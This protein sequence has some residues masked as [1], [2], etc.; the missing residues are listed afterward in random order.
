MKKAI[1]ILLPLV[2]VAS[3]IPPAPFPV[4]LK[5][6]F[7]SVLD[8]EDPPTRVVLGDSQ[9]FQVEKL[10]KSLVVKTLVP[11]ATSNMFVYFKNNETRLFVLTASEDSQPTYYKKFEKPQL[12]KPPMPSKESNSLARFSFR[13]AKVTSTHF[14]AKKDYLIV[15]TEFSADSTGVVKPNWNLVRLKTNDRTISPFKVW[16]ERKE[17]QKDSRI[18]ARFIFAK[19]NLSRDLSGVSFVVPLIGDTRTFSILLKRGVK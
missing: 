15:E 12:P 8:F 5:A 18:K 7:S 2:A 10:E 17:V 14:D 13:G 16:A 9:S 19:P 4:F 1:L 11:Y 3:E 6:G